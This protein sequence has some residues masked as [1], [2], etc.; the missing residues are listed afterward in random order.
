ML[1]AS[2]ARVLVRLRTEREFLAGPAISW[3][4][5]G[6]ALE[7][8]DLGTVLL[9][10]NEPLI[11]LDIEAMLLSAGVAKVEHSVTCGDALRWLQTEKPDFAVLDLQL[12]DGSSAVVAEELAAHA[13]PFIVYSGHTRYSAVLPPIFVKAIWLSKPCTETELAHAVEEAVKAGLEIDRDH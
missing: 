7:M 5:M 4:S 2:A 6:T 9:L 8:I 3:S 10:E 1:P 13:V 11:A 12:S